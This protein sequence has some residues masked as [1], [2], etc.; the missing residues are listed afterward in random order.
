MKKILL[1]IPILGI[2]SSLLAQAPQ[3]LNVNANQVDGTKDV[4][5]N[6]EITNKIDYSGQLNVEVWYRTSP[7]QT[8]WERAMSLWD[9]PGIPLST[10]DEFLAGPDGEEM[11]IYSHRIPAG[12]DTATP[13]AIYWEAGD[14]AHDVKTDQ[15]QVRVVVFY[16]KLDEFGGVKPASGQVSGWDGFDDGSTS[17]D[18][19]GDTGAGGDGSVNDGIPVYDL[20]LH[21]V[22]YL[23]NYSMNV[24]GFYTIDGYTVEDPNLADYG[25][26]YGKIALANE[27]PA[28][29]TWEKDPTVEA[30]LNPELT[31]MADVDNYIAQEALTPIGH[32]ASE[33]SF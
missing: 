15:A 2:C 31:T 11:V 12:G 9:T 16:E 17:G 32:I 4:Q 21:Q 30:D 23:S 6:F 26:F 22:E 27:D 8:Q 7:D 18:T 10:N 33:S 19:S 24:P 29:G 13:R 20:Q 1:L 5:I 3:V 25:V 28:S 14:D